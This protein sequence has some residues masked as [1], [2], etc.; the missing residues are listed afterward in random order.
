ME[1][2]IKLEG[3]FNGAVANRRRRGCHRTPLFLPLLASMGPSPTGD[4][5]AWPTAARL[6]TS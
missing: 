3:S 5:E 1:G 6:A 2:A 4:G